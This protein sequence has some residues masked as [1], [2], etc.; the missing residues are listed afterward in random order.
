MKLFTIIGSMFVLLNEVR[1][2]FGLGLPQF[3]FYMPYIVP[4]MITVMEECNERLKAFC[5]ALITVDVLEPQVV[6][7]VAA[8]V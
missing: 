2:R 4:H 3:L 7:D 5:N 6:T 8:E 1:H